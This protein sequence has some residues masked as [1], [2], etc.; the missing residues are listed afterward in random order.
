MVKIDDKNVQ[1]IPH[2]RHTNTNTSKT[3]ARL[4]S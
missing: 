2:K 3:N 1:E 4:N